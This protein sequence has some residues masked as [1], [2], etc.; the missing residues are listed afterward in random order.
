MGDVAKVSTSEA[1]TQVSLPGFEGRYVRSDGYNLGFESFAQAADFT[2]LYAGLPDDLCQ[3]PH[4]G[5]VVSGRLIMHRPEG[6]LTVEAGEGYYAGPGHTAE[7][8]AAGTVLFEV[9]P[10]EAY[11]ET[12]AVVA[13]NMGA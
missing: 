13:K 3:S 2:P 6:D 9:S 5:Y 7:I 1:D 8:A 10:A 11:D 12:M 4:W